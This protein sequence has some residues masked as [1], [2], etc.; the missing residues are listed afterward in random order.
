MPYYTSLLFLLPWKTVIATL[1]GVQDS[2]SWVFNSTS[3]LILFA[4]VSLTAAQPGSYCQYHFSVFWGFAFAVLFQLATLLIVIARFSSKAFAMR[5]HRL[6]AIPECK[7]RFFFKTSETKYSYNKSYSLHTRTFYY[8]DRLV[9]KPN[10]S[11][12]VSFLTTSAVN[13]LAIGSSSF[14]LLHWSWTAFE[15]QD[16][17]LLI[18]YRKNG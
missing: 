17:Q 15:Y 8:S 7:P 13:S 4:L 12:L 10:H 18:S 1:T 5:S 14:C 9:T 6:S 11:V 3:F 16:S 2:V